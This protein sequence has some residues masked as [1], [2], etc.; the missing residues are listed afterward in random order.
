MSIL[1]SLTP[2]AVFFVL[3]R[4]HSPVAGFAAAFAVSA[5]LCVHERVSGRTVKILEIGSLLLFG[6]LLAYTW[7][8]GPAWTVATVRLA[9][10][11]GL[12]AI[13]LVSLA[14]RR[15]FTLQYARETVPEQFWEMPTFMAANRAI[16]GVWAGAFAALCA[17]DAL[18]EWVP[19]VP[20]WVDVAGSVLAFVVAVW[21]SR[22]Y[23]RVVRQ[24]AL[25]AAGMT[26]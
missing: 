2:F 20:I 26:A 25:T 8:A 14:I 24:R 13:V 4:L 22:W 17:A 11:A 18:A 12:L 19:A 16:S 21:F 6:L 3:M 5:I 15:P 7:L 23:P 1:L 10:D 9:V